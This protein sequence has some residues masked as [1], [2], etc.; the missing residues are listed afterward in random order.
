MRCAV[1]AAAL[2]RKPS[3]PVSYGQGL[4]LLNHCLYRPRLLT[5]GR[6]LKP[7]VRIPRLSPES[8]NAQAET[9][10]PA[11][12]LPRCELHSWRVSLVSKLYSSARSNALRGEIQV[13]QADFTASIR[14]RVVG[15]ASG[16]GPELRRA[17]RRFGRYTSSW[18]PVPSPDA[19]RLRRSNLPHAGLSPIS[20]RI[21]EILPCHGGD[22]GPSSG[23][24]EI[25]APLGAC[26][27]GEVYR[28][29]DLR[30]GREVAVKVVP[31][32][33]STDPERL[34]L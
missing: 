23:P 11:H 32:G 30:L 9:E 22:C 34:L 2:K 28:T 27:H 8:R 4:D 20:A 33:Y 3:R 21:S 1:T 13:S 10:S 6:T 14:K 25:L 15:I 5:G 19:G 12:E 31:A 24:S 7:F 18:R 26:R 17:L 16:L 29:R